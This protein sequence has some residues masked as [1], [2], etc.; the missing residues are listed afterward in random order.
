MNKTIYYVRNKQIVSEK[1]YNVKS[2]EIGRYK[3]LIITYLNGNSRLIDNKMFPSLSFNKTKEL[4]AY[5]IA[6]ALTAKQKEINEL[7]KELFNVQN[8][9]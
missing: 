8:S 4:Y 1:C 6:A 7:A 5:S 2:S 3:D 9:K